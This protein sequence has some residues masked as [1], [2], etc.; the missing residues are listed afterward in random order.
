[1]SV[2]RGGE[3]WHRFGADEERLAGT[4]YASGTVSHAELHAG[5]PGERDTAII[6]VAK[7][8][9]HHGQHSRGASFGC[10]VVF[11]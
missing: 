11:H 1:M 10:R 9:V 3:P 5:R 6:D 8:D 2:E 4:G 7:A